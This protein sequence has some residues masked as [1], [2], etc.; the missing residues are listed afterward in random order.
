MAISECGPWLLRKRRR[1]LPL[2]PAAAAL[3]QG[4]CWSCLLTGLPSS[5]T[6][7]GCVVTSRRGRCTLSALGQ[8]TGEGHLVHPL[9]GR[10]AL[11]VPGLRP[12]TQGWR[13]PG[14]ACRSLLTSCTLISTLPPSTLLGFVLLHVSHSTPLT[15]LSVCDQDPPAVPRVRLGLL[16]KMERPVHP[17]LLCC[18]G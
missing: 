7:A 10:R 17:E 13:P 6:A 14:A 4:P 11:Q 1:P 18:R 12:H 3:A 9:P 5:G 15:P 16:G 8:G 2:G